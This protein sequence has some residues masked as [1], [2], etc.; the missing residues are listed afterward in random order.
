MCSFAGARPTPL[1]D[2]LQTSGYTGRVIGPVASMA[3]AMTAA[4]L[5]AEPGDTVLL[6][7]GAASFGVFQNEFDRG[8]QFRAAV[9]ALEGGGVSDGCKCVAPRGDVRPAGGANE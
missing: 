5:L 6:A 8:E 9:R 7:P 1:A 3:D 2:M 4:A